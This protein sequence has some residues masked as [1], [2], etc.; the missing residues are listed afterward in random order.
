MISHETMM[1]LTADMPMKE[2][3]I[4]GGAYLQRY[5]AHSLADGTHK[6][7]SAQSLER[8]PGSMAIAGTQ[9]YRDTEAEAGKW[10]KQ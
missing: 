5:F 3:V 2:I 8:V 6:G 9:A 10:L 1:A 7:R 4:N